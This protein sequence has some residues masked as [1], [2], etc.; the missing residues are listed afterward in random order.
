[1]LCWVALMIEVRSTMIAWGETYEL[2][3]SSLEMHYSEKL[4]KRQQKAKAENRRK[5]EWTQKKKEV[6][7]QHQTEEIKSRTSEHKLK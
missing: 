6:C 7:I 5:A 1:L 4:E 2:K 3:L